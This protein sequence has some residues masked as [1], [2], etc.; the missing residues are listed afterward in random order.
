MLADADRLAG[1]V[2]VF[3]AWIQFVQLLYHSALTF[4]LRMQFGPGCFYLV[5]NLIAALVCAVLML[6]KIF[7]ATLKGAVLA[8]GGL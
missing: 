6:H 1:G 5:A 7:V 3:P 4:F 2:S 8:F